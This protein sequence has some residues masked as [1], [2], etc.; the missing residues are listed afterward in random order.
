MWSDQG[1]AAIDEQ[2]FME[3]KKLNIEHKVYGFNMKLHHGE[4][5]GITG[6][7]GAGRSEVLQSVFGADKK[8]SGTILIEG[9]EV[10]INHPSDAIKTFLYPFCDA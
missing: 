6:L 10:S 7:V 8:K 2:D 3:V 4:I 9:K 1:S 5:L